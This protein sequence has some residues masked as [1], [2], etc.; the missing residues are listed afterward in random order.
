MVLDFFIV[1]TAKTKE[2]SFL[3]FSQKIAIPAQVSPLMMALFTL[4]IKMIDEVKN[5][6]DSFG[7]CKYRFQKNTLFAW[8]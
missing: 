4:E 1:V 8:G 6:R 5:L 2:V 7:H 3:F